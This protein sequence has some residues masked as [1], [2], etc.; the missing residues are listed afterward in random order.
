MSL[1]ARRFCAISCA[2]GPVLL[3]S[4]PVVAAERG[5]A[6]HYAASFHGRRTASGARLDTGALTCAH[7]TAPF[8]ALLRVS[9]GIRSVVC[10]VTDRGSFARGRIIDLTPAAAR[11]LGGAGLL[12]VVVDRM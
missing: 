4:N 10:R 9:S 3:M 8:G 11:V 2:I 5:L 7:R 1:A 6:S 12:R